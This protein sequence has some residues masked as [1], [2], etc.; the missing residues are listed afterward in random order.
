M[1]QTFLRLPSSPQHEPVLPN[2]P[3]RTD[4]ILYQFQT[5]KWCEIWLKCADH[6]YDNESWSHYELFY[7]FDSKEELI[8]KAV[9][10]KKAVLRSGFDLSTYFD[11]R[12]CVELQRFHLDVQAVAYAM[13]E[14]VEC[15]HCQ[16][17]LCVRNRGC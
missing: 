15:R 12:W 17:L 7:W 5:S 14:I 6:I 13:Y 4:D 2:P 3:Q 10:S 9:Q 11:K 16:Y 8:D 1:I